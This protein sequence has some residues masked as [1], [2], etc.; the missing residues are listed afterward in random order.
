MSRNQPG[1]RHNLLVAF[2]TEW[3]ASPSIIGD[4][5]S[6]PGIR[7]LLTS[8]N[9]ANSNH[10]HLF[11]RRIINKIVGISNGIFS[12]IGDTPEIAPQTLLEGVEK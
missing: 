2:I 4:R 5:D 12:L 11:E 8:A 10:E 7:F 3:G 9:L 6:A 1:L